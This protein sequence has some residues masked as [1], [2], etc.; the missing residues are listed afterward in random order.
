[1]TYEQ[2]TAVLVQRQLLSRDDRRSLLSEL[3]ELGGDLL[4]AVA[5]RSGD[6]ARVQRALAEA[7]LQDAP[8]VRLFSAVHD[9]AALGY[10]SA[11]DAWDHLVLP[12]Q[13]EPDGTVVCCTTRETLPTTL[14]FLYARLDAPFRIVLADLGPLELYIAEQYG[15]EGVE[16]D[17]EAA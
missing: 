1:M 2:A 10:L 5:Q 13:V 7:V 12:L 6:A 15:Y 9:P 11:R 4:S 17:N 3:A 14:A 16:I 8:R